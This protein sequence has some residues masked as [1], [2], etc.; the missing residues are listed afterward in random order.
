[1]DATPTI[2]VDVVRAAV[3][4]QTARIRGITALIELRDLERATG[5][6]LLSLVTP[7]RSLPI[8][9]LSE[10]FMLT[11]G[12]SIAKQLSS[13]PCIQ[14]VFPVSHVFSDWRH[15]AVGTPGFGLAQ[16]G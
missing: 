7:V 16:Y 5:V 2:C 4:E 12:P 6:T 3:L 8:E 15:V 10:I 13:Q 9:L 11:I 1:M 14:D